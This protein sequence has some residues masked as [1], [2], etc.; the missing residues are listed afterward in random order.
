MTVV[1]F[2]F[3]VWWLAR[4]ELTFERAAQ[5][6]F[7]FLLTALLRRTDFISS[8]F[9]PFPGFAGVGFMAFGLAWDALTAG[10]GANEGTPA[11]PRA[12]RILL[13]L[14][15]ILLT[16]TLVNWALTAHDLNTLGQYTGDAALVGFTVLGRPLIF[17]IVALMLFGEKGKI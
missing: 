14:G 5:A 4:D 11:L 8:P 7:L 6:L 12:S 3:V 17:A 16:A 1:L 2:G 13:Y 15:Y 9:S 10:S